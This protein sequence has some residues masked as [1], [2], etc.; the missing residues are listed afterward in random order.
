MVDDHARGAEVSLADDL[1]V[2]AKRIA[3]FVYGDSNAA[4]VRDV[5][6]NVLG[7]PLF[8]HGLQLAARKSTLVAEIASREAAARQAIEERKEER[9]RSSSA[10]ANIPTKRTRRPNKAAENAAA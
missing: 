2:S 8:K 9:K 5:Y 6:R 3:E 4:A 10:Q 7:L 1:I